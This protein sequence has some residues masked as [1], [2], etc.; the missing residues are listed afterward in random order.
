MEFN[1]K[2]KAILCD[3]GNMHKFFEGKKGRKKQLSAPAAEKEK[4]A[5]KLRLQL[6][7]TGKN[8]Y[9]KTING[10]RKKEKTVWISSTNWPDS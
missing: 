9:N 2:E 1:E 4:S 10:N 7:D 8:R 3:F 5:V 6:D